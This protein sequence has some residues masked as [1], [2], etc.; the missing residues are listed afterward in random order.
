M[1]EKVKNRE[2]RNYTP[3]TKELEKD[4]FEY[5]G[6]KLHSTEGGEKNYFDC[7][8]G[9][10]PCSKVLTELYLL[11]EE[12]RQINRLLKEQTLQGKDIHNFEE[13]ANYIGISHSHL[14]RLT[15]TG[16][17]SFYKPNGKKLYFH[18]DDLDKF[19]LRNKNFS[20]SDIEDDA[21]NFTLKSGRNA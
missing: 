12:T 19:L 4:V 17:I 20:I 18:R 15:S 16:K 21:Q 2:N 8:P 3:D 7:L 14:Y 10:R 13:A 5:T 6:R 9:D 11:K 1:D